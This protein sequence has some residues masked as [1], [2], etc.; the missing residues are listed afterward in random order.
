MRTKAELIAEN[1]QLREALKRIAVLGMNYGASKRSTLEHSL[2]D[3][4]HGTGRPRTA[5]SSYGSR[6]RTSRRCPQE[7]YVMSLYTR[8]EFFKALWDLFS[9]G[10]RHANSI[11]SL[12]EALQ[13]GELWAI[14]AQ[15]DQRRRL[16]WLELRVQVYRTR[17]E[18]ETQTVRKTQC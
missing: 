2:G 3:R 9:L 1:D 10:P 6:L 16:E 12:S 13:M 17:G 4:G 8:R 5:S 7:D 11:F 14:R 15:E 18:Y